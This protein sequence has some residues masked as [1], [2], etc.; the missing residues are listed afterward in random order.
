MSNSGGYAVMRTHGSDRFYNPPAV[1]RNQQFV[2]Q[3][4]QQL[5]RQLQGPLKSDRRVDPVEPDMRADSEESTLSRPNSACSFSPPR[6]AN[7]TNLDRLIASVTPFVPAQLSTEP[8]MEGWRTPQ[9][10]GEPY[11]FYLE[12]LWESVREWSAYGVTVPMN[13]KGIDPVKQY[14][15]PFLSAIQV[16]IEPR[17]L[18]KPSEDYDAVSQKETGSVGSN[19]R[20]MEKRAKGGFDVASISHN[21][22]N[23]NAQRL[24]RLTLRD[25]SPVRS[26]DETEVCNSPGLLAY[27]FFELDPPHVRKPFHDKVNEL[28]EDFPDLKMYRSCDL[29]PSSWFSVAWYPIYRI[30]IGSTL[31]NVDASFL[32]FHPL[33]TRPR[34]KNQPQFH[35]FS[36]KKV[37]GVGTSSP[38][39]SLPVF[40]LASY[41]LRGSILTSDGPS[42]WQQEKSLLQAAESWLRHLDVNNHHDFQFFSNH[43]SQ[44][45]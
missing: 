37:R 2:L 28:A 9:A 27:E 19:D 31:K 8:R 16:Y 11:F 44:W 38:K 22:M 7:L 12:D 18:R 43:S 3:Q 21:L 25:R 5:K 17:R 23:A 45:R 13:L 14:Y 10:D 32:T 26:T 35:A 29:L 24:N 30:P 42:E 36:G 6:T 39:I 41:K 4:Q 20:E 40:G 1:R 34:S 15:V 33:S